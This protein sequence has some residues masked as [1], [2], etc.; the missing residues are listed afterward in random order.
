MER[1]G[2]DRPPHPGLYGCEGRSACAG[3]AG[4]VDEKSHA[5]ANVVPRAGLGVDVRLDQDHRRP[6]VFGILDA[7]DHH[8]VH[9]VVV[10]L[11]APGALEPHALAVLVDDL[12]LGS[13]EAPDLAEVR[14]DRK[15]CQDGQ[16][17]RVWR[18][19]EGSSSGLVGRHGAVQPAF[20]RD[21]L[22]GLGDGVADADDLVF[23]DCHDAV[24]AQEVDDVVVAHGGELGEGEGGDEGRRGVAVFSHVASSV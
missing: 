2:T 3:G 17:H 11:G 15:R 8:G 9:V 14:L 19:D 18:A 5:A 22:D 16:C 7:D 13:S 24:A 23:V 12:S 20:G 10:E 21:D 4:G 6:H 1:E